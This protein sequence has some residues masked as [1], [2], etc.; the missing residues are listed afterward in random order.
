MKKEVKQAEVN[1]GLI[2]HVD[3]GKTSLA[4]SLTGKW[5]DTHSEELK[6]GISIRLGYAD[7]TFYKCTHC[8]GAEAYCTK[9]I[10]PICKKKCKELRKV[11][12]VDAPGHETLM[13]TML[14]GA[15]L[16][17]GA[18]LVIAANEP[19]PQPRTV[20]HLMALKVSKV[21]N[22]IVAQNKI[23]LVE[24]KKAI[25]NYEQIVGF[26]KEFGY[27]NARIIPT[28][29]HFGTNLDLL[30]EAIEETIPSPKLDEG[31]AFRMYV[32]RSFDINKPGTK[33]K[34][35][36]GGVLGGTVMQGVAAEEEEV[37]LSPGINGKKI[38]TKITEISTEEGKIK[39]AH[40]GGLIAVKTLLD[41]NLSK[42]DQ[43][44][45][46]VIG[47]KGTVPDPTTIVKAE[48]TYFK[49]FIE[50][51]EQNIKLN[52]PIVLSVGTA[53]TIADIKTIKGNEIEAVTRI[54]L[55]I[56]KGQIIALSK[57]EGTRWRLV[58]YG[59]TM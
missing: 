12:F 16:M 49:R 26:L 44:K 19:C 46:Q 1:I 24:K 11:S 21:K 14:S 40:P 23:D 47:K 34:K 6:R 5:T 56:E 38:S 58:A 43:M 13:T 42:N 35:I 25:E 17:N 45:G 37:E 29:A 52:E 33:A 15:A 20:E 54:P 51:K 7:A 2:G 10:C 28:A 22:I 8:K 48:I 4:Y 3:H 18:I 30:I 50:A 36:Q 59:E 27:E 57:K 55:A 31:D 32:A 9:S 41:P 53:A 39:K